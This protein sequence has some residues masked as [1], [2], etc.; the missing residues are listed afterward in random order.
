MTA[1][2]SRN[3]R[4]DK[5][6]LAGFTRGSMSQPGSVYEDCTYTYNG[7]GQRIS[8][9]Y[10]YDPNP[11]VS[12]DGSYTYTTTY[13]YDHSGRLINEHTVQTHEIGGQSAREI[14]YLYDESG[15]IGCVFTANGAFAN[16][17]AIGVVH[18][19]D[20]DITY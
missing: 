3:F 11:A 7:Y 4:W 12:N 16:I 5:G 8:K 19:T 14:T 10:T 2:Q 9:T 15:V 20:G 18:C 6:K 17:S 13:K 1:Y